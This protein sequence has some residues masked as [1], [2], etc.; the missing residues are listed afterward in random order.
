MNIPALSD[1]SLQDLHGL[2]SEMVTADD[3]R[4]PGMKKWGVRLYRDWRDLSNSYEAELSRR[5]LAFAPISW[6]KSTAKSNTGS[7]G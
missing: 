2:I 7:I 3:A 6:S 1:Q 5:K 4:A